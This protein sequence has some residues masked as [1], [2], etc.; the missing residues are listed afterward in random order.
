[1]AGRKRPPA[2]QVTLRVDEARSKV[3][4]L[5]ADDFISLKSWAAGDVETKVCVKQ[6]ERLRDRGLARHRFT[7]DEWPRAVVELTALGRQALVQ[8]FAPA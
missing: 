6:F 5:T 4:N 3:I 1:M 8:E 2:R 7:A